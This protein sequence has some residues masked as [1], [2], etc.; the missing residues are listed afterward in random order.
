VGVGFGKE[1][2]YLIQSALNRIVEKKK[3][4]MVR[5]WGKILTKTQDY[6]IAEGFTP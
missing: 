2:S 4:A 5:F 6:L 3:A 1:E